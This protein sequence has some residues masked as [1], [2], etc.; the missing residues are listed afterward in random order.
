MV[1]K[2]IMPQNAI[3]AVTLNCNSRCLSCDIWKSD[4][5]ED[6]PPSFYK[7]LPAS[8]LDINITGGDPFLRKDLPEIV[9]I[10]KEKCRQARI[11]IST[12]GLLTQRIQDTTRQ[13][14]EIDPMVALRVSIDGPEKTHDEIRGIPGGFNKAVDTIQALLKIGV[15]DLGIGCTVSSKNVGLINSVYG[16]ANRLGVEFSIT[17]VT[18]SP[19]YFGDKEQFKPVNNRVLKDGFDNLIRSELAYWNKKRWARAYY[20]YTLYDY[21]SMQKRPFPCDA[22]ENFFYL[23]PSG[24][25]YPC[26][27]L[28]LPIGNL[29]DSTF[30]DIWALSKAEEVRNVTR[31]CNSCWMV[32]TA[33][34]AIKRSIPQV[35]SWLI[36]NRIKTA[37]GMRVL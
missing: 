20:D 18:S 3:V 28:D 16:L 23:D 24:S 1:D 33:K 36:K 11:I 13:I 31:N 21:I 4:R 37:L 26:D 6:I 19:I 14:L 10:L 2:T 8:L 32:C 29:N 9:S 25:V 15:K 22:G 34:T 17:S 30:E 12:N 27:I 5:T 7:K 35:A